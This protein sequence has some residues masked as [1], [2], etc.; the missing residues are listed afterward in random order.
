M[1]VG[2]RNLTWCYTDD[3]WPLE[4]FTPPGCWFIDS[5]LKPLRLKG[6]DIGSFFLE[7]WT[8]T[9]IDHLFREKKNLGI[10]GGKSLEIHS[11]LSRRC[12][13]GSSNHTPKHHEFT[14]YRYT[15]MSI[16]IASHCSLG[17][18]PALEKERMVICSI[19]SDILIFSLMS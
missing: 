2:G 18:E 12:D 10:L 14:S 13:V 16:G 11:C 7:I 4:K 3:L 15:L 8:K 9:T 1:F 5:L 19:Y 6:Q 17:K